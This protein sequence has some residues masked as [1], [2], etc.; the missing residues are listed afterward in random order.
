MTN[1]LD[2]I[3]LATAKLY[4][5]IDGGQTAT[6]AEITGMINSALSLIEKQTN[7][8]MFPRSKQ[9]F[10]ADYVIVYDYPINSPPANTTKKTLYS[11]V[12]TIGGEVTLNVGAQTVGEIPAELIDAALQVINFWFYNSETQNAQNTLPNF[13]GTVIDTNRRFV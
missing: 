9:Y 5:K 3:S 1:Y 11:I 4:L 10:G 12:P 7:I 6:D 2:I 13:V 8:I